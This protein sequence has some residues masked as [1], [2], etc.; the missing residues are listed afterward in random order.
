MDF[1]SRRKS[2]CRRYAGHN[3]SPRPRAWRGGTGTQKFRC[4]EGRQVLARP[5]RV[6][7]RRDLGVAQKLPFVSRTASKDSQCSRRAPPQGG[8]RRQDY[9]KSSRKAQ[10]ALKKAPRRGQ[11]GAQYGRGFTMALLTVR[12]LASSRRLGHSE[13]RESRAARGT[14]RADDEKVARRPDEIIA[15]GGEIDA[16]LRDQGAAAVS[17]P[18]GD[19]RLKGGPAH[20]QGDDRPHEADGRRRRC[21]SGRGTRGRSIR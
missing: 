16:F 19:R 8:R 3:L 12:G 6:H 18:D 5:R 15:R 20:P 4:R 2:H 11:T 17:T 13:G 9:S 10:G 21:R 14:T 7:H 1:L